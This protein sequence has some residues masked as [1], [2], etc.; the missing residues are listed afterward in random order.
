MIYSWFS[1][2]S[3][4]A[5]TWGRLHRMARSRRCGVD[6]LERGGTAVDNRSRAAQ[7]YYAMRWAGDGHGR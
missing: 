6:G 5:M 7:R 4:A 1:A 3:G 2:V